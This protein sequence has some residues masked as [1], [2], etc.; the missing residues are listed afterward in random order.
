[1][2][3]NLQVLPPLCINRQHVARPAVCY[4]FFVSPTFSPLL[5]EN[6][7]KSRGYKMKVAPKSSAKSSAHRPSPAT[8]GRATF[9]SQFTFNLNKLAS[10]S[11]SLLPCPGI[12]GDGRRRRRYFH[13]ISP[14]SRGPL[15]FDLFVS[16]TS[17]FL[18]NVSP[19]QLPLQVAPKSSV[20]GRSGKRTCV[21]PTSK[22]KV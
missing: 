12:S 21:L 19:L 13:F 7:R 11:L 22:R 15:T 20:G 1:M 5:L 3:H 10:H 9:H 14:T 2:G 18:K 16:P 8:D 17:S 4:F 6:F